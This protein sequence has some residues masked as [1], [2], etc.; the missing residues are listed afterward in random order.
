MLIQYS[1]SLFP[2][3]DLNSISK[4]KEKGNSARLLQLLALGTIPNL[5][6]SP[7]NTLMI[8]W[9]EQVTFCVNQPCF[10]LCTLTTDFLLSSFFL[11]SRRPAPHN[12]GSDQSCAKL[13]SE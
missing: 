10:K 8:G 4:R 7:G 1:P 3:P 13:T 6:L 9:D 12:V 5:C 2:H 11:L